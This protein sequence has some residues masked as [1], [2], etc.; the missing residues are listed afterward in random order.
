MSQQ[1]KQLWV[2]S[3][4]KHGKTSGRQE[5]LGQRRNSIVKSNAISKMCR[6]AIFT[7]SA[8]YHDR[9]KGP[10]SGARCHV[11][12]PVRPAGKLAR[13]LNAN[14]GGATGPAETQ[15]PIV[16]AGKKA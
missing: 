16:A 5:L 7:V 8:L 13:Q 2:N 4:W 14:K 15:Y 9:G 3:K 6:F 12:R 1:G 11:Q 10:R